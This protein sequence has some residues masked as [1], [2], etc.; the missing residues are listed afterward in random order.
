M[1]S[2]PSVTDTENTT[3]AAVGNNEWHIADVMGATDIGN[4]PC[5]AGGDRLF[6]RG[7]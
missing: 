4:S 3:Q 7:R 2:A 5:L 1:V 6:N